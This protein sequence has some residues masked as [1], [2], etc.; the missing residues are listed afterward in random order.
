M[1]PISSEGPVTCGGSQESSGLTAST[2]CPR[3]GS[4]GQGGAQ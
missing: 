3:K 2:V 4:T 1:V